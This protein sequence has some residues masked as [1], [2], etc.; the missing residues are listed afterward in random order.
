MRARV[1][2][3][4]LGACLLS[5]CRTSDAIPSNPRAFAGVY[6]YRSVDTSADK[7][8]D[9]ELDRLTLQ[10]GGRYVLVRGGST[11]AR[12]EEVGEWRLFGGDRPSIG[13]GRAGYPI[14]MAGH[15]VRLLI[16]EDLGEWWAKT[17]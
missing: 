9:H 17:S 7:P 4:L 11:K 8:T 16:N 1:L 13:L 6:S 12:S 5:G 3:V 15:E 14:Q 2:L 10:P